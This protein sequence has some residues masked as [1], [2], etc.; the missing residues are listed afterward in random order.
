[1]LSVLFVTAM[2][3]TENVHDALS[4]IC[5][6]SQINVAFVFQIWPLNG[7]VEGGTRITIEG[8][9]LGYARDQIENAVTVGQGKCSVKEYEISRRYDS[10]S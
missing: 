7:P 5:T 6:C 8:T 2:T 4:Q 1:M 3:L 10:K 9:N